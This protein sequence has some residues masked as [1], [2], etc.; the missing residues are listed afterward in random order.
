MIKEYVVRD[1]NNSRIKKIIKVDISE[2]IKK[3]CELCFEA[4]LFKECLQIAAAFQCIDSKHT[5]GILS[6]I[7]NII[8]GLDEYQN[9]DEYIQNNYSESNNINLSNLQ[10]LLVNLSTQMIF[11][12][13][14]IN[15]NCLDQNF[16]HKTILMILWTSEKYINSNNSILPAQ[17][18]YLNSL[19]KKI[20]FLY[21]NKLD[22]AIFNYNQNCNLWTSKILQ[23]NMTFCGLPYLAFQQILTISNN[24]AEFV[25]F[26][27]ANKINLI[28]EENLICDTTDF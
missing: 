27:K 26:L 9:M 1:E 17:K 11:A 28:F 24:Q 12:L 22:N 4:V 19:I 10:S 14:N 23:D 3:E 20:I 5:Y 21:N 16:I 7:K 6:E 18:E 15:D 13:T 25:N 8:L 2:E